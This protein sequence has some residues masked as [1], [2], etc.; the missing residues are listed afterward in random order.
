MPCGM[1]DDATQAASV[2]AWARIVS[3]S[4]SDRESI[5]V[6]K[7][8]ELSASRRHV[9]AGGMHERGADLGG[10][11][12]TKVAELTH[13]LPLRCMRPQRACLVAVCV[14]PRGD[15]SLEARRG[16]RLVHLMQ[17]EHQLERDTGLRERRI[18]IV[19][20]RPVKATESA[21]CFN[22]LSC[23]DQVEDLRHAPHRWVDGWCRQVVHR[24]GRVFHPHNLD[25]RR[26]PIGEWPKDDSQT[27]VLKRGF[28][29]LVC[30]AQP[31]K[32]DGIRSGRRVFNP[33][34]YA[35]LASS[36]VAE[37]VT[38]ISARAS[39]RVTHTA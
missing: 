34:R 8:L 14:Q 10:Q 7:A 3:A 29:H 27:R 18:E 25:F 2:G 19:T 11:A 39:S 5:P 31:P 4:R 28:D 38:P 22:R 16:L 9:T 37:A 24:S 21:R 1:S 15:A 32:P 33:R 17:E 26:A 23:T 6:T 12:C 13:E 30:V 20:R 35:R 36:L